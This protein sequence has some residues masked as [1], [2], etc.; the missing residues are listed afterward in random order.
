MEG[1]MLPDS[2]LKRQFRP[3]LIPTLVTLPLLALM[4]WASFWQYGRAMEKKALDEQFEQS[5]N[6]ISELPNALEGHRYQRI[7]IHGRPIADTQVLLDG[8]THEGQ[9]GYRVLLPVELADGRWVLVDRGFI[10][11]SA[12]RSVLPNVLYDLPPKAIGEFRGRLADLPKPGVTLTPSA[13][14]G[15]PRR[16]LYPNFDELSAVLNH[17][18]VPA[19]LLLDQTEPQ[20][21]VRDWH[22]GGM[23]VERHLAYAIQWAAMALALLVLFAVS[24]RQVVENK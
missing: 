11:A 17:P 12:N 19:I 23:S 21:F 2:P 15:W 6:Q 13:E 9:V 14:I 4:V 22:P 7:V 16:M 24:Q 20:G 1:P 18:V 3:R 5:T 8:M 10:A